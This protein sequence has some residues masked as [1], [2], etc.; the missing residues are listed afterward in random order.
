MKRCIAILMVLCLSAGLVAC[1]GPAPSVPT[2]APT[3]APGG[4]AP[5]APTPTEPAPTTPTVVLDSVIEQLLDR[6]VSFSAGDF[7][8]L[9]STLAGIQVVYPYQELYGILPAY[10]QY[11][12]LP[13][14][15]S[16]HEN[17][18]SDGVFTAQELFDIVK[19]NNAT[20]NFNTSKQISDVDLM[21]VCQIMAPLL[22]EYGTGASAQ[23]AS[24][25]SEKLSQLK[26]FT[27][28]GFASGSYSAADGQLGLDVDQKNTDKFSRTVQHETHHLLQAG[29]LAEHAAMGIDYRF[30]Y[31]YAFAQGEENPLNLLWLC[32]ASS[33]LLTHNRLNS[34]TYDVY[35]N[36]IR[37]IDYIKVATLLRPDIDDTSF[38]KMS[39]SP[40]LE[41]LFD[42]FGCQSVQQQEE[43][44]NM[45]AALNYVNNLQSCADSFK[46]R[47][48][49]TYGDRLSDGDFRNAVT[50]ALGKTLSRE[51]FR[52]FTATLQGQQVS[53][54]EI[55]TMMALFEHR[56]CDNTLYM[57]VEKCYDTLKQYQQLQTQFF[58][59]LSQKLD[60]PVEDIQSAYDTFYAEAALQAAILSFVTAQEAEYLQYTTDAS[61]NSRY[62]S[63]NQNLVKYEQ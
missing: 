21:D 17:Y 9:D 23:E 8:Q 45:V 27:F 19:A 11:L 34:R 48:K 53:M 16:T 31:C 32:E 20:A 33:E 10:Q 36:N 57:P 49:E 6:Q 52:N 62:R 15:T 13:T 58:T 1:A 42:Y 40:R 24:H 41:G 4:T 61:I 30:G 14:Y 59:V 55:F 5:T 18:F 63:V 7:S 43:I 25:L 39:L 60:M 56:L 22:L 38:E 26:I 35:H 37:Y 2:A 44:L 51:F 50:N 28:S 47:Y 12:T 46:N 3:V 29:T 54:A